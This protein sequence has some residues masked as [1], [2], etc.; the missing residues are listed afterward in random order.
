MHQVTFE[1]PDA[2]VNVYK[3]YSEDLHGSLLAKR[4]IIG[5]MEFGIYTDSPQP[6]IDWIL[7]EHKKITDRNKILMKVVAKDSSQKFEELG[8]IEDHRGY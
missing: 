3:E 7:D 5:L 6:V 1:V 8:K 2:V 4:I